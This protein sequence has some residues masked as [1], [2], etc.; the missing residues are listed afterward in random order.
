[1]LTD[2]FSTILKSFN[3]KWKVFFK[4][5]CKTGDGD[6]RS[7]SIMTGLEQ[8]LHGGRLRELDLFSSSNGLTVDL[9]VE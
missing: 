2:I 1:M 4:F 8:M 3:K 7:Y 9:T 5:S 6:E